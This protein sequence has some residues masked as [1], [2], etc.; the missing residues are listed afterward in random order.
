[1]AIIWLLLWYL[2]GC[3]GSVYYIYIYPSN[4]SPPPLLFIIPTDWL[5]WCHCYEI[6]QYSQVSRV[7]FPHWA[8]AQRWTVSWQDSAEDELW[9]SHRTS[10]IFFTSRAYHHFQVA[11]LVGIAGHSSH[12]SL[13][14][15]ISSIDVFLLCLCI[16]MSITFFFWSSSLSFIIIFMLLCF[17]TPP[18][19]C[20]SSYV[21]K[22][23]PPIVCPVNDDLFSYGFN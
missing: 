12:I 3:S 19:H 11:M 15:D 14:L 16:R 7:I 1:M 4:W 8:L 22:L 17:Q 2:S 6:K 20:M 9:N 21:F 10:R 18:S 13:D 23:S 5:S